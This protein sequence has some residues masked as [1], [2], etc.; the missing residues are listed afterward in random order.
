MREAP[1]VEQRRGDVRSCRGS[2]AGSSTAAPPPG[3]STPGCRA[4]RPS[5][6]RSCPSVRIT[7]RP[8]RVGGTTV[9]R[10]ALRDQLVERRVVRRSSRVVPGDE[11]L[12]ALAGVLEQPVELLVEDDQRLGLLALRPPRRAAGPRRRCSGR[13]RRRRASTAATVASTKPRWL[14]HMIADAVALDDA[15]SDSAWASAL[16]RVSTSLKVSVPELVDDHRLV[17]G[18]A[19]PARWRPAAG[20]RPQ[21]CERPQHAPAG[22]RAASAGSRPASI[23]T[24]ALPSSWT[25]RPGRLLP[26]PRRHVFPDLLVLELGAEI[27]KCLLER[28]SPPSARR[29]GPPRCPSSP[30]GAS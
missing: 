1:R 27:L 5:A 6:C 26:R 18:S 7:A 13:A 10:V 8:S 3:R 14:R 22:G 16:V 17:R 9:A 20:L 2:S 15:G 25:T 19:R 21:R 23:S 11:A 4:T 29:A 28:R 30:P 24:F 12:A